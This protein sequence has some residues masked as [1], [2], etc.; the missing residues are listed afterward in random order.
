MP[1]KGYKQTPEHRAK[2]AQSREETQSGG[3][4]KGR[5]RSEEDRASIAAGLLA[6]PAVAARRKTRICE[7]CAEEFRPTNRGTNRN[8]RF[9]SQKCRGLAKSPDG[10]KIDAHGYMLVRTPE[11]WR[12]EHRVVMEQMLGRPITEEESVHH[13]NGVK[14][15][16][17]PENLELRVRYHGK[18]ASNHCPTCTCDSTITITQN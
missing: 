4:P 10:R 1:T 6:S 3:W 5:A 16:N 7:W 8:Q 11:G 14:I 12:K 18:G 13:R 17:R 15:D 9:C 2:I